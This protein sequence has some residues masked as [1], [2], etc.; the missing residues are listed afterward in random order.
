MNGEFFMSDRLPRSNSQSHLPNYG[1]GQPDDKNKD[2]DKK[3]D[4]APSQS[5]KNAGQGHAD[6]NQ[7]AP[8]MKS[9]EKKE[10]AP[11]ESDSDYGGKAPDTFGKLFLG[12]GASVAARKFGDSDE[13]SSEDGAVQSKS[14]ALK[15]PRQQ[16]SDKKPTN[17]KVPKLSLKNLGDSLASLASDLTDMK[18]SSRKTKRETD[19]DT[20]D[21]MSSTSNT[22]ASGGATNTTN[23]SNA[24]V[25][26]HT[27]NIVEVPLWQT[28]TPR[29]EWS[30]T[31]LSNLP[32]SAKFKETNT[33]TTTT[34]TTTTTTI[35]EITSTST[36]ND[37]AT[38]VSKSIQATTERV[39]ENKQPLSK[40]SVPATMLPPGVIE[41]IHSLR[42]GR[43]VTGEQIA[44]LLI[45]MESRGYTLPLKDGIVS[46]ILRGAMTV[47]ELDDPE[48][49]N[50]KIKVNII[51]L[52]SEKFIQNHLNVEDLR[53]FVEEMAVKY[54]KIALNFGDEIKSSNIKDLRKNKIFVKLM[55]PLADSFFEKFFGKEMKL[56]S[57][58]FAPEFKNFLQG[59]DTY[60]V[61][62]AKATGNVNP[63]LLL[64]ARK[65][66][67]A[68][69]IAT[70]GITPIMRDQLVK[71][72][73]YESGRLDIL[74][75]YLNTVM[76]TQTNDFYYD[77]MS[78]A[79][80]QDEAQEKLINAHKK[81]SALN[82]R[83]KSLE[84]R[85][86]KISSLAVSDVPISP[87]GKIESPRT[88]K[89]EKKSESLD[90]KRQNI[91]NGA[92]KTFQRKSK[93]KNIDPDFSR[94]FRESL[95]KATREQYQ[96]FK[97]NPA[98]NML[99]ALEKYI[100]DRPKI[101]NA[102]TNLL[103]SMKAELQ[104]LVDQKNKASLAVQTAS[105]TSA[106][107]S[108]TQKLNTEDVAERS[109]DDSST[110]SE[111]VKLEDLMKSPFDESVAELPISEQATQGRQSDSS[112][113][114]EKVK[115]AE[116]MKSPFDDS[117]ASSSQ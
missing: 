32:A 57:S 55:K 35:G 73:N 68:A 71:D 94:Y 100:K 99:R 17:N 69:F 101:L 7:A 28:A 33:A 19:R 114:S 39:L 30:A 58:G 24:T 78:N 81:G 90:V 60:V 83:E 11:S 46:T 44:E 98:E 31:G 8:Q 18:L 6:K 26:H 87:R 14:K 105:A 10:K 74:N 82:Q 20:L 9:K 88:E 25:N 66:A 116:I 43:R 53:K 4:G 38:H 106:M 52:V 95:W 85:R 112:E 45:C 113:S 34:T 2:V 92:I 59:I 36:K 56:S 77:I 42:C 5:G 37:P 97:D 47:E 27:I 12:K 16:Q 79:K 76:T 29:S 70:R 49:P 13:S 67:I 110:S 62:W 109:S 91:R 3:K 40:S 61:K 86:E 65:S 111:E 108:P 63:D 64:N 89:L 22:A 102:G 104:L 115:L 103:Q 51:E 15:S 107:V 96:Q 48:N 93:I 50:N 21:S 84:S 72:K 41:T 80:N 75:G 23:T 117:D 1:Q 54:K